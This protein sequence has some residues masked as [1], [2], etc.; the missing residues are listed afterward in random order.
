MRHFLMENKSIDFIKKCIDLYMDIHKD[1]GVSISDFAMNLSDLKYKV[2]SRE[3]E[4]AHFH[5]LLLDTKKKM[6]EMN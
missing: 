4:R 1:I 6:E 5:K 3:Q 2:S